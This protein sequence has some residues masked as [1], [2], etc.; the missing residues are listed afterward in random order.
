MQAKVGELAAG[1]TGSGIAWGAGCVR[2][3]GTR[4]V[5]TS[6]AWCTRPLRGQ[7]ARV[8]EAL[9][10]GCS[11]ATVAQTSPSEH[12][13]VRMLKTSPLNDADGEYEYHTSAKSAGRSVR[14]GADL[15]P[16]FVSPLGVP[17]NSSKSNSSRKTSYGN[18]TWRANGV[19]RDCER[20]Q[21]RLC[22]MGSNTTGVNWGWVEHRENHQTAW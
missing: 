4:T 19:V 13:P 1:S 3:S 9:Q 14:V 16:Q 8:R 17:L 10:G 12:F 20:G 21:P 2:A 18:S 7:G 6:P 15:F 22:G 5:S 11:E